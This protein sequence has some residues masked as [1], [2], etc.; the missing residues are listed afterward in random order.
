MSDTV[1]ILL[2]CWGCVSLA[3]IAH[4]VSRLAKAA[5]PVEVTLLGIA[6]HGLKL[7]PPDADELARIS[8][9]EATK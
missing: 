3:R 7:A 6:S 1:L 8:G 2:G 5:A 4:G 9:Q